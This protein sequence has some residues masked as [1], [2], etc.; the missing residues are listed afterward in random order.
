M[1]TEHSRK[2]I[3]KP[4]F[5]ERVKWTLSWKVR[6]IIYIDIEHDSSNNDMRHT[7]ATR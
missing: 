3:S 2:S 5:L 4:L 1:Y 7:A 6:T